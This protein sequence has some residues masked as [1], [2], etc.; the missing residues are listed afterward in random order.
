MRGTTTPTNARGCLDPRTASEVSLFNPIALFSR[1]PLFKSPLHRRFRAMMSGVPG[2]GERGLG[3]A[4]GGDTLSCQS[5]TAARLRPALIGL[6]ASNKETTLRCATCREQDESARQGR[7]FSSGAPSPEETS[8]AT[9]PLA[10]PTYRP[11]CR[12]WRAGLAA[13]RGTG[14]VSAASQ[15]F[16][17]ARCPRNRDPRSVSPACRAQCGSDRRAGQHGGRSRE[18]APGPG[19]R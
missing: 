13:D 4:V 7:V 19:E 17:P 3:L 9:R 2:A 18:K 8:V 10:H 12:A 16:R 6:N 11:L 14:R 1:N 15:V 5:T